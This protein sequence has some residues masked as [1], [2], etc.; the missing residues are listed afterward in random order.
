MIHSNLVQ[1]SHNLPV[2]PTI[3][4]SN[5]QF[6][7]VKLHPFAGRFPAPTPL[8]GSVKLSKLPLHLQSLQ[9]SVITKRLSRADR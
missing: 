6:R 1:H 5:F 4:D 7:W 3:I 9:P 8:R 2:T